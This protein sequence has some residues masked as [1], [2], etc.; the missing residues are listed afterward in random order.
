MPWPWK[1]GKGIIS[2]HWYS[3]QG[4]VEIFC[5]G[6]RTPT[7]RISKGPSKLWRVPPLKY[8]TNSPIFLGDPLCPQAKFHKSPIGFSGAQG[9][10]LQ[11]PEC[12]VNR[13]CYPGSHY[14]NYNASTLSSCQITATHLTLIHRRD[15]ATWHGTRIVAQV[16]AARRHAKFPLPEPEYG[17]G[18]AEELIGI[19]ADG[20]DGCRFSGIA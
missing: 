2:V 10:Y 12:P 4:S 7:I 15:L 19:R 9:P 16:I 11:A 18:L 17:A 5:W 1:W 14:W 3:I 6:Y 20:P 8:I 13:V